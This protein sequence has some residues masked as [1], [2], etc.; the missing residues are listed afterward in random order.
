MSTYSLF[1][2]LLGVGAS[3]GLLWLTTAVPAAQRLHWLLAALLTL[4]GAL[5]GARAGYVLEHLAYFSAHAGEM[6][7]FWLGGLT[8]EGGLAGGLLTVPLV[9]RWW[10]WPFL[11][12]IDQ[13]SRLLFPLGVAGWAGCW[14]TGLGYGTSLGGNFWWGMQTLDESGQLSLRTPVQ[15]VAML[16]L[17]VFLGVLELWLSRHSETPRGRRGLATWL[18]F[19]ATMLPFT[20]LRADPAPGWLGLRAETWLAMVYTLLGILGTI[21]FLL[22]KRNFSGFR[23]LFK[24]SGQES[25]PL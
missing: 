22:M 10:K 23:K 7:R 3:F 21:R 9:V 17:L 20:F 25:K 15:P 8:W 12:V 18:I 4:L 6:M 19:N 16:S 5:I 14:L 13:L 2:L 24:G 1:S 11:L